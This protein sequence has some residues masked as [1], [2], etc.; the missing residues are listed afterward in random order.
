MIG[1]LDRRAFLKATGLTGAALVLGVHLPW[2]TGCGPGEETP[3]RFDPSVFV[4]VDSD[5]TVRI[6]VQRSEMG[7]GVRTA[8]AMLVAEELDADWARVR[9]EQADGHPK[10]GPQST[11][12]SQSIRISWEPLR[13]AGAAARAMLVAAAAEAWGVPVGECRTESGAVLHDASGRRLGYGDLAAGA[14]RMP[15]PDDPPL[16]APDQYRLIGTSPTLVDAPDMVR[17]KAIYAGDVRLPGML[18][19]SLERSPAVQGKLVRLDATAARAVPGVVDVVELEA[20]AG[21]LANQAVAVVAENTWAAMKGRAALVVEWEHGPLAPESTPAYTERLE[22]IGASPCP[23]VREEGNADAARASAVR[24][25]EARYHV[26]YAVHAPMEPPACTAV[27]EADRCEAW[28]ATQGPQWAR[29]EAAELLGLPEDAV[30]LHVTLLG[31]AFGRK[32]KPDFVVEAVALAKRLGRPVQVVWTREDE[33]RHGFYRAQSFQLLKAMLDAEGN[34]VGW[35]HRSVYPA[36][37]WSFPPDGEIHEEGHL[38]QGLTNLPYRFPYL[39]MEAGKVPSSLRIGWLRSVCNTFHSFATNSF[40]D[41]IAHA[42]GRDTVAFHLEMLGEPRILEVTKADRQSPYKFDTGRLKGVIEEVARMAEWGRALPERH[43]LGFAAQYS[44]RSFAA[45]VVHASVEPEGALR[46]HEVFAA[47]DCG[48]VVHPDTIEAQVQGSVA[49]GLSLALTG[50]I[51]VK[52]GVV[53]QGNF[54]DYPILRFG[55]MP[56]VQVKAVQTD[57]LPTGIGE[58]GVPPLAPA[59]CNAIFAA[60]GTRIRTLPLAGQA[61]G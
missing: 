19:A 57:T 33:V 50:K 61:L 60:T 14:A 55:E 13:K 8:V 27:V 31:G 46:V 9:V 43:G 44:F 58:P 34:P 6:T 28:A 17:G 10:Y 2:A 54:D 30:T 42:T 38:A 37:G 16:K 40:M 36:I 22:A 1:K 3:A 35:F 5:G 11:G 7:Q 20:H 49:M 4:G 45:M 39:R 29:G 23:V 15:I 41:E 26:P 18:F 47:I 51:T 59:L 25:L 24:M 48:P 56:K 32:S 52:D 21:H 12:G 53:E